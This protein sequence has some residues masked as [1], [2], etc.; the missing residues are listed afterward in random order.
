MKKLKFIFAFI[1][2]GISIIPAFAQTK[3]SNSDKQVTRNG[4]LY[5][6]QEFRFQNLSNINN[7]LQNYGFNS[8]SNLG[9]SSGAGGYGWFGK[10]KV[11]GEGTYFRSE[12]DATNQATK[13]Q[14]FGGNMYAAYLINPKSKIHLLPLIGIGGESVNLLANKE[15]TT[16]DFSQV[17]EQPQTLNFE[18]GSFYLKTALQLEY[19]GQK[20]VMGLQVGYQYSP[21]QEWQ[22]NNKMLFGAPSDRLSNFFL[23]FTIGLE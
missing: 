7:T 12:N 1:V 11:G 4:G 16:T 19:K 20:S 18:T 17:V 15:S 6:F 10:F 3:T 8:S 14:G 5:I 21:N 13:L 9:Y 2:F 22:L 23:R